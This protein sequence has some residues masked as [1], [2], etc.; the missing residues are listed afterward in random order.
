MEKLPNSFDEQEVVGQ[1]VAK[2]GLTDKYI[3]NLTHRHPKTQ[4]SEPHL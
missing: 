2:C 1:I 4:S 3:P